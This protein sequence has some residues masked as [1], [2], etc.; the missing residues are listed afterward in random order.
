LPGEGYFIRKIMG[1][2]QVRKLANRRD[3]FAEEIKKY[4]KMN[5]QGNYKPRSFESELKTMGTKANVNEVQQRKPDGKYE[6][7]IWKGPIS[8]DR[9]KECGVD[10]PERMMA[11]DVEAEMW[12]L[13]GP[14]R[15]LLQLR[16]QRHFADW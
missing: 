15:P 5:P 7:I 8:A 12:K 2:S 14:D 4:L 3:F 16:R 10:V 11:D 1:R 6:I 9:M 13:R